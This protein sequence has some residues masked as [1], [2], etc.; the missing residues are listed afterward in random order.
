M[1]KVILSCLLLASG[2][3]QAQSGDYNL[4]LFN[5][6]INCAAIAAAAE[7]T[8][9]NTRLTIV[10]STALRRY[11]TI[12]QPDNDFKDLIKKTNLDFPSVIFGR[13][14]SRADDQIEKIL[15]IPDWAAEKQFNADLAARARRAELIFNQAQCTLVK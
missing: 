15:P 6:S 1:K 14:Q 3:A 11:L 7:N 5:A 8:T 10:A 9:E 2:C 12:R 4:D 13:A